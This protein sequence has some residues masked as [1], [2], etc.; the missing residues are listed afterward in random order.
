MFIRPT[1]VSQVTHR[2]IESYRNMEQY[3]HLLI[4]AICSDECLLLAL[5]KDSQ[6]PVYMNLE[7]CPRTVKIL[8][9]PHIELQFF[10]HSAAVQSLAHTMYPSCV[11]NQH[12]S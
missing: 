11:D 10:G 7:V 4:W 9:L 1:Y 6:Y 8:P 5:T 12:Q 3:P 2:A